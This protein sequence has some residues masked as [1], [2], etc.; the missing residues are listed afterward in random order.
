M[1]LWLRRGKGERIHALVFLILCLS[2]FDLDVG[3]LV[4]CFRYVCVLV[5]DYFQ[6]EYIVV[7]E[8]P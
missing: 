4:Y 1:F 5:L 7:L 3:C 8:T 6:I 2:L